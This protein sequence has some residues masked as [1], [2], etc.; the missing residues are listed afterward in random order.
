MPVF[1]R[2]FTLMLTAFAS[3]VLSTI[4]C[5]P[6]NPEPDV[7]ELFPVTLE[8]AI[9]LGARDRAA[10]N[11]GYDVA[12]YVG[13][14][15][16]EGPWQILLYMS[17]AHD[18]GLVRG[19]LGRV[20][21]VVALRT[22]VSDSVAASAELRVHF[23]RAQELLGN[24][25]SCITFRYPEMVGYSREWSVNGK[26]FAVRRSQM[27][28]STQVAVQWRD[29]AAPLMAKTEVPCTEHFPRG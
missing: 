10:L 17:Q 9:D 3:I 2:Q 1:S 27:G 19:K 15:K 4:G 8:P 7:R 13:Y 28:D 18:D 14:R 16:A 26:Y 21:E 29:T 11:D 23:R 22:Y 12:M 20:T 25:A 6:R 24:P 5:G